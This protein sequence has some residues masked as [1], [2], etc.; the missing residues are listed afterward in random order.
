MQFPFEQLYYEAP[1]EVR[2]CDTKYSI[3]CGFTKKNLKFL[4]CN[5]YDI[6]TYLSTATLLLFLIMSNF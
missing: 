4:L 6:C 1:D 3:F 2:L 5:M